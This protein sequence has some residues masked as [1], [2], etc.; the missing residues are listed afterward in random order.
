MAV[1]LCFNKCPSAKELFLVQFICFRWI[2]NMIL[3]NTEKIVIAWNIKKKTDY[4]MFILNYKVL[5]VQPSTQWPVFDHSGIKIRWIFQTNPGG[6][7]W[8]QHL[9]NKGLAELFFFSLSR[10]I[11]SLKNTAHTWTLLR[12][13]INKI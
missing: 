7:S 11:K 12:I 1:F 4:F 13:L 3:I 9:T 8:Y 5:R 6:Y 10:R 2:R